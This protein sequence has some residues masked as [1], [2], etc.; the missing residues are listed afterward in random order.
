M[1]SSN[2]T[3]VP[4]ATWLLYPMSG[5]ELQV[6]EDD[7]HVVGFQE[8]YALNRTGQEHRWQVVILMRGNELTGFWTDLGP[9][10]DF[11]I[12]IDEMSYPAPPYHQ[13]IA[14]EHSVAECQSM[15]E[16]DR[17]DDYAIQQ[18]HTQ[19]MESDIIDR[20]WHQIHET[21]QQF[22]NRSVFGPD[23][24]KERNGFSLAGAKELKERQ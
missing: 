22:A 23:F 8:G 12:T 2:I 11:V 20:Y 18:L 7:K 24:T 5:V 4:V 14:G 1:I 6:H 10:E 3:F 15:A 13:P 21:R 16:R 19:T 9:S 17:M